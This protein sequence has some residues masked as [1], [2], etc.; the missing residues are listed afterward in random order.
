[1]RTSVCSPARRGSP[2]AEPRDERFFSARCGFTLIE[3]LVVVAIIG[4]LASM[5][6]P[7]LARAKEQARNVACINNLK[8][9]GT[10]WRMYVED[11]N[12]RLVPNNSVVDANS[13]A[14][15]LL[16]GISWLPDNNARL[17]LDPSNIVNGLLFRYN[18]SLGIYHCPS[19]RSTLQTSDGQ[20]LPQLR[21]RSYNMSQ[22]LNGYPEFLATLPYWSYDSWPIWKTLSP[23]KSAAG[24]FVFI[25]E[26]EDAVLDAEFGNPPVGS[27][28]DGY[29]WDLPANRHNQ[30]ANLSFVDS[31]VEHW[32]WKAPKIFSYYVQPVAD[33]ER[34]DYARIQGAMRQPG[35]N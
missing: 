1:M 28:D 21:W 20:K 22:S 35:N 26:H 29:W 31:H 11:F 30:G 7:V 4:I 9:L 12:D 24:T 18:Q 23:I 10:C 15:P 16:Q 2:L 3:L 8:Q 13:S 32:K 5:L 34:A 17:E 6:L 33:N 19:D 14:T 27:W 25:D